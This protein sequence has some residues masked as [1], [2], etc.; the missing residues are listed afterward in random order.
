MSVLDLARRSRDARRADDSRFSELRT[1]STH[2]L[3]L[4][5]RGLS[6]VRNA[7]A[8]HPDGVSFSGSLE[9]LLP[10]RY[11]IPL[12]S[13]EV[14]VRISKGIGIPAG[15]PDVAG[16]A[17]RVPPLEVGATPWDLLLAGSATGVVGRMVPWPSTSWNDAHLSSLMPVKYQGRMWW[18]RA[19]LTRPQ[20]NGMSVADVRQAIDDHGVSLVLE[21]ACGTA[22]FEPLAVVHSTTILQ[23]SEEI[24]AFDPVMNSPASVRPQPEWLRNLRLSAYRNSRAGRGVDN[25]R[26]GDRG[27]PT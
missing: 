15:L 16:V 17:I 4:P 23:P 5:F 18:L 11:G 9:R 27:R 10:D 7:R 26:R 3:G 20:M 8:F 24:D 12:R 13:C 2:L 19:R 6:A 22:A 14:T 25:V 21:H 1:V